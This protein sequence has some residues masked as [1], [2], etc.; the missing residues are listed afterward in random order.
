MKKTVRNTATKAAERTT[1][2]F[3]FRAFL[4]A[5]RTTEQPRRRK[6]RS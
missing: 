1:R 5:I 3:V 2:G 4:R 6:A